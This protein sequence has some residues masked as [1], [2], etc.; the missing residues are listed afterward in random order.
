MSPL[1]HQSEQAPE[2]DL[3]PSVKPKTTSQVSRLDPPLQLTRAFAYLNRQFIG[4]SPFETNDF[5]ASPRRF[6]VPT[7]GHEVLVENINI[8]DDPTKSN[9]RFR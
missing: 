3:K 4:A 7:E 6:N 2:A 8:R 1:G 9:L 5:T